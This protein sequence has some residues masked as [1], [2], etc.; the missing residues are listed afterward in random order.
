MPNITYACNLIAMET[1][2]RFDY[3][4]FILQQKV[5]EEKLQHRSK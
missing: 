3:V 4:I 1:I 5:E 2:T